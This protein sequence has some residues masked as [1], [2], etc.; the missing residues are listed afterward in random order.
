MKWEDYK[1][2]FDFD[3]NGLDIYVLGTSVS[4][5]QILV[6]FIRASVYEYSFLTA[7]KQAYC[8]FVLIKCSSQSMILRHYYR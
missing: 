6:D 7:L 4:D 3:G 1:T 8:R 2:E 5:W